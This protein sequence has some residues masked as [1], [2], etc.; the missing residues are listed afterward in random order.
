ME[1]D[2][3]WR[4]LF[5]AGFLMGKDG[6]RCVLLLMSCPAASPAADHAFAISGSRL[7]VELNLI[8]TVFP[9]KLI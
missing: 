9:I 1:R 3:L 5:C 7:G 6:M 8:P 2:G 4:Y